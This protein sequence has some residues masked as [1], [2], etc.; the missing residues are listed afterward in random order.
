MPQSQILVSAQTFLEVQHRPAPHFWLDASPQ[1]S[2]ALLTVLTGLAVCPGGAAAEDD[3]DVVV[4]LV[5]EV[6]LLAL[7]L[8]LLETRALLLVVLEPR[9]EFPAG[10]LLGVTGRD[11]DVDVDDDLGACET[12][13]AGG[14]TEEVGDR[15]VLPALS[16]S[17]DVHVPKPL[18]QPVPQCTVELPQNPHSEQQLPKTEPWQEVPPFAEPHLPSSETFRLTV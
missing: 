7:E 4:N 17:V 8:P 13:L 12:V 9:T 15:V 10:L 6:V 3:L 11:R 14:R 5:E 1:L 2:P 16:T 18:W